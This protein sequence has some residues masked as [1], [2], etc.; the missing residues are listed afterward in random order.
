MEQSIFVIKLKGTM[1]HS[2][3]VLLYLFSLDTK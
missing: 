2:K 1:Q 3:N